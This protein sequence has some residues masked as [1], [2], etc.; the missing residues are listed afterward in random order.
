[1]YLHCSF[2]P[3]NFVRNPTQLWMPLFHALLFA[4]CE[5]CFLVYISII[6]YYS[7]YLFFFCCHKNWLHLL[8]KLNGNWSAPIEG[9]NAEKITLFI[10]CRFIYIFLS[11]KNHNDGMPIKI[12]FF[13]WFFIKHRFSRCDLKRKSKCKRAEAIL[14]GN[15]KPQKKKLCECECAQKL[16]GE[17]VS[18]LPK[19]R[20]QYL[21][22]TLN[23]CPK[24]VQH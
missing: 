9:K 8:L 24:N 23:H 22:S 21:L 16:I 10:K 2:A 7:F 1:M 12:D 6:N 13:A 3:M 18:D 17:Q 15:K 4:V 19:A 14:V 20:C 11:A 5:Y